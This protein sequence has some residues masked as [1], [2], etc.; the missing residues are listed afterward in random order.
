VEL[1]GGVK[2]LE[3][4]PDFSLEAKWS[5][6]TSDWLGSILTFE[7]GKLVDCSVV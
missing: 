3:D 7:T 1:K 5:L 4:F 6:A 2:V